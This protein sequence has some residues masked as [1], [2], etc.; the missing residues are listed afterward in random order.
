MVS[1]GGCSSSA[2]QPSDFQVRAV[3]TALASASTPSSAA[4][5][6]AQQQLRFTL[7]IPKCCGNE[8]RGVHAGGDG[9]P[10][11]SHRSGAAFVAA[12]NLATCH[13]DSLSPCHVGRGLP[14]LHRTGAGRARRGRAVWRC[15][16]AP[17]LV[18]RKRHNIYM[19]SSRKRQPNGPVEPR[20]LHIGRRAMPRTRVQPHFPAGA[21]GHG[22]VRPEPLLPVLD[23]RAAQEHDRQR[24]FGTAPAGGSKMQHGRSVNAR[25]CLPAAH[26]FIVPK[27]RS[28][29]FRAAAPP[30][31]RQRSRY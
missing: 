22:R 8:Q 31:W 2:S 24:P 16:Q 28:H 4:P 19:G 30:H 21:S 12:C 23:A 3:H 25:Q 29:R 5:S 20:A 9:A 1:S 27:Q 7:L 14:A 17:V 6:R 10:T 11:C 18:P 26:C 13:R 15:D